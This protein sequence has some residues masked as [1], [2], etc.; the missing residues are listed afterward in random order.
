MEP[1][2]KYPTNFPKPIPPTKQNIFCTPSQNPRDTKRP[3][4][5]TP[6]LISLLTMNQKVIHP[7]PTTLTHTTPIH[8]SISSP[9]KIVTRIL[10]HAAIQTKD[11]FQGAFTSQIPFQGKVTRDDP[12]KFIRSSNQTNQWSQ[13]SITSTFFFFFFFCGTKVIN[14]ALFQSSKKHKLPKTSPQL[15]NNAG[16]HPNLELYPFLSLSMHNI[17]SFLNSTQPIS[18]PSIGTTSS[19]SRINITLNFYSIFVFL[20][21]TQPLA[22]S[23]NGRRC[24]LR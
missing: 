13:I 3:K 10:P 2:F 21:I 12:L 19:S 9:P 14:E 23:W 18:V 16:C 5:R 17:S 1:N 6:Q 20:L 4:Y 11:T 22:C 7:L 15:L 24:N 8:Y